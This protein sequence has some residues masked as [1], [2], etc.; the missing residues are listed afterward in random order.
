MNQ[1]VT[2][3]KQSR[4]NAD[5]LESALIVLRP[6]LTLAKQHG[7]PLDCIERRA[8]F[9]R[10]RRQELV[11]GAVGFL[12]VTVKACVVDRVRGA[13]GQFDGGAEIVIV[14]AAFR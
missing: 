14:V 2:S 3:D 8:Q 1:V 12:R 11:F 9:V 13:A 6:A 10:E 4:L 5:R 7:P